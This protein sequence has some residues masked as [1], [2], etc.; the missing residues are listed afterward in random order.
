MS[1]INKKPYIQKAVESL[2]QENL[3]A[4]QTLVNG[5]TSTLF[6]SYIN[7]SYVF[8]EDDKGVAHCVLETPD[9]VFTGYLIYT[10]TYCVLV[11]YNGEKTQKMFTIKLDYENKKYSTVDE[12]LNINEFRRIVESHI[13]N[14][15]IDNN[16]VVANPSGALTDELNGIKID[17]T[18]YY[19]P[20]AT[21]DKFGM[22]K[23]DDND[24]EFDEETGALK[25]KG[26]GATELYKHSVVIKGEQTTYKGT[27]SFAIIDNVST[28]E[29]DTFNKIN[30]YFYQNFYTKFQEA[31]GSLTFYS[32][33]EPSRVIISAIGNNGEPTTFAVLGS[34]IIIDNNEIVIENPSPYI[35]NYTHISQIMEKI[36]KL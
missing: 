26:G 4:L 13:T 5:A 11:C 27:F 16:D 31:S 3:E 29:F 32:A 30:D 25:L 20:V 8:T 2:S 10:D 21:T 12:D 36:T 24:F 18:N 6:R 15:T 28:E 22:V 14:L 19:L 33:G 1:V 17:G 7:P 23:P 9:N 35:V 34:K